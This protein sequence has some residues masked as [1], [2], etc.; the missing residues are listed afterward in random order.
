MENGNL[1]KTAIRRSTKY[2]YKNNKII[3]YEERI[4]EC[5]RWD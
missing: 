4:I 3:G 5:M 1:E 2:M